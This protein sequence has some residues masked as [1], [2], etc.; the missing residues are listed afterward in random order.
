MSNDKLPND[1]FRRHIAWEAARLVYGQQETD[2]YRAKLR[3][4]RQLYRGWVRQQDLP[5]DFEVRAQLEV[6]SLGASGAERLQA[7]L[8]LHGEADR[9]EVY[10]ALLAPL[11]HVQQNPQQHPEG[12]VLYHSLQVFTLA[13]EELPYDEE[14]LLAALLHDVGKA[15]DPLE[16]VQAGLAALSGFITERTAWLIENHPLGQAIHEGT[17]GAR[18]RRRLAAD[19]SFDELVL[20]S[21]CDREGRQRG[22]E[23]PDLDEAL[24]Y[25][26]DLDETFGD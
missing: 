17:I 16:H 9:F 24:D 20:L 4:A 13:R 14:L 11:E 19:E 21:H 3:A 1:K 8:D 22:M 2:L 15:I 25:V 18:A 12:D 5:D 26:R 23:V 10:R 7:A 6:L